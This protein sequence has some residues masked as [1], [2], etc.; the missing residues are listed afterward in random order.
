MT[1]KNFLATL[2]IGTFAAGLAVAGDKSKY[3]EETSVAPDGSMT[4][5]VSIKGEVVKLDPGRT[6]VLRQ[7]S[8]Q[9]MSYQLSP[10]VQLPVDVQVG[11][12]VVLAT[13][14]AQTGSVVT[15]VT[16]EGVA[17]GVSKRTEKTTTTDPMTG[18]ES[19]QTTTTYTV[20]GFQPHKSITLVSPDGRVTTYTLDAQSQVPADLTI[21][22]H[23]VIQTDATSGLPIVRRMTYT[24]TTTT[25]TT[26]DDDQ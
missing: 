2:M 11:R 22:K 8:G 9:E 18:E 4:K 1:L 17:P 12:T 7:A 25:T 14:P 5:K 20:K 16:V 15:E 13:E 6:I 3:N 23:V 26:S 19:T 24:K 10:T 21:G